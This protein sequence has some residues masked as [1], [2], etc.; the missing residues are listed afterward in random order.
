MEYELSREGLVEDLRA[1][2][3][4]TGDVVLMH[5]DL[6]SLA[7]VRQ[8]LAAP[9]GGMRWLVDA[10]REVLGEEG[11]LAVP[12]FT[13]TFKPGQPG[14]SG[15]VW[16]PKET[17]SRVG[18][19]TN[20]VLKEPDIRRSNH[21]TH[22]LAAV[23]KGAERFVSGHSWREGAST[24][25]RRGPWGHL[26]DAEGYIMWLGTAMPTQ[27]AC[28]VLE[29]WMRLPYMSTCIALVGDGGETKEVE[30]TQSP[31][32]HRDFYRKGSK[33]DVA[34]EKAGLMRRGKVCKADAS[35]MGARDFVGWLWD[36]LLKAPGFLLCDAEECEFCREGR[37]ATEKHLADFKGDWRKP[38]G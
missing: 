25:D 14:P 35:L 30:V 16:N 22:S 15:L 28:H 27:T 32:G 36:S 17:P 5:S 2:G 24:F 38:E 18:T 8:I 7:P 9:D 21:P 3:L 13:K 19:I 1:L 10:V 12:T 31:A 11:I 33:V 20:Y 26:V 23:G 29:D 34:W 6:R 37:N 4:K